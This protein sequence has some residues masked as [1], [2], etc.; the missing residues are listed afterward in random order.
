M[1]EVKRPQPPPAV[2]YS[3]LAK[4]RGAVWRWAG[5]AAVLAA[6]LAAC[7]AG[8]RTLTE[9]FRD[10]TGEE[11][12]GKMADEQASMSVDDAI[13]QVNRMNADERRAVM[14]SDEARRF[15]QRQ[16]PADRLR[17]VEKTLDRGLQVQ[18]E[19]YRKLNKE[20]R[21]AFVEEAKERQ[22]ENRE[23]MENLPPE[24]KEKM[25][26]AFAAGNMQEMLDRAV[27]AY[28]SLTTSE[29]RAE[30]APLYEGALENLNHARSLK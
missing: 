21:A 7:Y 9:R 29:E 3:P 25:R 8:G 4:P 27:K 13:A 6:I 14:Q 10:M 1:A 20:E 18:L 24:E 16:A 30:L 5:A 19:R 23:R 11:L 17:F 12:R 26:Q 22:R 2:G 28:L 15:I